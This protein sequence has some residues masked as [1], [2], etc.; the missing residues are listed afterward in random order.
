MTGTVRPGSAR[1]RMDPDRRA[2]LEEERDFL[3]ASLRDLEAEH[4]AGDL[5]D[6]DYEQLRDDYTT[7]A[8]AVLRAIDDDRAV[9]AAVPRRS[10]ARTAA[11]VLGVLAFGVLAGLLVAQAAGRRTA[12]DT[13]SGEVRQTTQ[14]LLLE[15]QQLFAAGDVEAALAAYDEVLELAPTNVEALT[16]RAW[17]GRNGGVLDDDEALAGLDEALAVDGEFLDARLFRAI[18]LTDLGRSAEA[19]D[20]LLSL[21]AARVPEGMGA[22]VGSFGVRV[23]EARL[24]EGDPVEAN[25]LLAVVLEVDPGNVDAL[26]GRG[27]LLGQAAASAEGEDQDLLLAQALDALDGAEQLAPGAPTVVLARAQVLAGVGQDAAALAEL[28]ELDLAEAPAS[29]AATAEALRAELGG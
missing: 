20:D 16:Y 21:D 8:A 2:A 23:A 14:D 25:A 28:D 4:E 27:I 6:G 15:A 7:R 10:P 17:V 3:L 5:D 11:W 9:R 12:S 24:A 29:V 13:L 18:V 22:M 1:R 19:A 26:L